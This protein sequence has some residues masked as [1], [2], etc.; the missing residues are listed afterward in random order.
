MKTIKNNILYAA[1]I[2]FLMAGCYS[3][4][5]PADPKKPNLPEWVYEQYTWTNYHQAAYEQGRIH[6]NDDSTMMYISGYG[7]KI[8]D[9]TRDKAFINLKNGVY[10]VEVKN[11]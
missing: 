6:F 7:E 10:S 9:E 2:V 1:L 11:K 8:D 5:G 3:V 4:T